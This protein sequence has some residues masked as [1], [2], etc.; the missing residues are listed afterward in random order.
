MSEFILSEALDQNHSEGSSEEISITSS[1]H[2]SQLTKP[3]RHLQ[4]QREAEWNDIF[5]VAEAK[6]LEQEYEA[7]TK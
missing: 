1:L 7:K 4:A 3:D 6:K 5:F 2:P